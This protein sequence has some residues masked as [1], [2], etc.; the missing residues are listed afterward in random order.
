MTT[1][2]IIA[3]IGVITDRLIAGPLEPDG[4]ARPQ[5]PPDAR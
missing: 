3:E 5:D 2:E 4:R 1:A